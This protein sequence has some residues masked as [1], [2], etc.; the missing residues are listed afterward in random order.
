[1]QEELKNI[2]VLYDTIVITAN[3]I[4]ADELKAD[5]LDMPDDAKGKEMY[6]DMQEVIA[7]GKMANEV[8]IDVGD[9]I[10]IKVS[11]F[12]RHSIKENSLKNEAKDEY[13]IALP[14]TNVNGNEVMFISTRDVKYFYKK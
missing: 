11:N 14:L 3:K 8:G 10:T 2:N 4:T 12:I 6:S 1:M 5:G 7:C 13:S 9:K